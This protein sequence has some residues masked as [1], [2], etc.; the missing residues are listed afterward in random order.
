MSGRTHGQQRLRRRVRERAQTLAAPR[1][2]DHRFHRVVLNRPAE[3]IAQGYD[4]VG[5]GIIVLAPDCADL[6]RQID[7]LRHGDI[8]ERSERNRLVRADA[9]A[10]PR[11]FHPDAPDRELMARADE[12]AAFHHGVFCRPRT[13]TTYRGGARPVRRPD[14]CRSRST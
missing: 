11:P 9:A 6:E 1:G 8:E 14:R 10:I 2:Q 4:A 5:G 12:Y 3:G 7:L 13:A